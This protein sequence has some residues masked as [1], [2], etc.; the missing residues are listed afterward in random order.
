M[1]PES[2]TD[3]GVASWGQLVDM[4]LALPPSP[5]D[6]RPLAQS[7]SAQLLALEP[8][9]VTA[10]AVADQELADLVCELGKGGSGGLAV[11]RC[12]GQVICFVWRQ[13]SG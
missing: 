5:S 12:R 3:L 8:E 4:L 11:L 9:A 13:L 2:A 7:I 6:L 10:A 1:P